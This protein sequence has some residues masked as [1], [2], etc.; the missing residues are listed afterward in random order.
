MTLG[1]RNHLL[2]ERAF[3]LRE[4]AETPVTARLTRLSLKA[5]LQQTESELDVFSIEAAPRTPPQIDVDRPIG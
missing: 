4:L 1:H 2:G 3:L 5:R